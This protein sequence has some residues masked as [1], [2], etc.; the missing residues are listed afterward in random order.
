MTPRNPPA[1]GFLSSGIPNRFIQPHSHLAPAS[2]VKHVW[3]QLKAS[4]RGSLPEWI[5]QKYSNSLLKRIPKSLKPRSSGSEFGAD[6]V[7][8]LVFGYG[9][10]T[11]FAAI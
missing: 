6:S 7:S 1:G 5:A 10:R 11:W 2:F 3:G 4:F 8:D 9:P